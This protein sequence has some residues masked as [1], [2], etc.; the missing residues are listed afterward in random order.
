MQFNQTLVKV[1]SGRNN[2]HD[3]MI[4][5]KILLF[6]YFKFKFQF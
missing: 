1:Y 5:L 3:I 6:K 2:Y 4:S